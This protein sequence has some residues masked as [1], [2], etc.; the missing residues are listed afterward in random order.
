MVNIAYYRVSTTRQGESGL[1]LEAQAHAIRDY[2]G[3]PAMHEFTE[4]ESGKKNDRPEL[5]KALALARSIPGSRLIVAK[6]DRLSRDA[7]FLT[8]LQ[9]SDVEFTC[10]DM[11]DA[12]KLT[13]GIMALIAQQEREAISDRTRRA[14]AAKKARG[15]ILGN[16]NGAAALRRTQ[17][18]TM[19][20]RREDARQ[21]AEKLRRVL[22][23][24]MNSGM[25]LREVAAGLNDMG[26]ATS[27][28][29]QWQAE[30][31]RR[32]WH[33]LQ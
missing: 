1:G 24:M 2:L 20:K 17:D 29:K 6:L 25:S 23:G 16:P 33:R 9:N 15:A 11:P 30:T 7:A 8:A 26:V 18:A 27:R 22:T 21:A 10:C 14:L 13:V 5:A 19:A 4:I 12:N 3:G 28:G 31:V 32:V